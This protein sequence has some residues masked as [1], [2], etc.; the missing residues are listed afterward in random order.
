MNTL[1]KSF[2]PA[3]VLLCIFGL[4]AAIA[5]LFIYK[6]DSTWRRHRTAH[7]LSALEVDARYD[8]NAIDE[9]LRYLD[10]E[11]YKFGQVYACGV[12]RDLTPARKDVID[13]LIKTLNS[14][15]RGLESEAAK[16]LG[17]FGVNASPAIESLV[18][19][20]EPPWVDD[21]AH[22]S[23]EA[24]G[25]IGLPATVAIPALERAAQ[26][27]NPILRYQALKS[28]ERL[29]WLRDWEQSIDSKRGYSKLP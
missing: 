10:D 7:R 13:A 14:G 16:T 5:Y 2:L 18:R 27:E 8:P 4:I 19:K 3:I 26:S 24:L 22:Y 15:K 23:A 21:A 17:A 9:I 12:L 1:G 29:K 20:L 11:T 6:V 25:E 28:L